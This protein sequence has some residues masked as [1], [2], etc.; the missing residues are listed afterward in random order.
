MCGITGS[1]WRDPSKRISRET[2]SQ[3]A[4]VLQHRGPDDAQEFFTSSDVAGVAFGFRRLAIIDLNTGQ[5]PVTNDDKSVVVMLNGE[6]YNYLEL[7]QLLESKGYR[8]KTAGDSEV[9]VHMYS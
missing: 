7:R 1:V 6:I 3:M 5:Q 8:F 9:I 4:S 2:L